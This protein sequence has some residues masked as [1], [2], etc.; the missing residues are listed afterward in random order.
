MKTTLDL[1]GVTVQEGPG[2]FGWSPSNGSFTVR[3]WKGTKE[4]IQ[5]LIPQII[6]MGYEYQVREGP[7]WTLVAKTPQATDDNGNPEPEIPIPVFELVSQRIDQNLIESTANFVRFLSPATLQRIRT[8]IRDDEGPG[9]LTGSFPTPQEKERAADVYLHYQSGV[10]TVPYYLPVLRKTYV[11]SNQYIVNESMTI[12]HVYST[13]N[14][15]SVE[16]IPIMM[17]DI[18]PSSG[19]ESNVVPAIGGTRWTS[20]PM[21]WGWLKGSPQ[22]Q[23]TGPAQ[24]QVT[25]DY[26]FNLWPE[27]IYGPLDWRV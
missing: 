17:Q 10:Q 13:G 8:A 27:N 24:F 20:I 16:N 6:V 15:I 22:Y 1:H 25:V 23:Q 4:E 19:R 2:E 12:N 18:L 26:E 21:N 3:T 14:L 7:L 11:V 9:F 5:N